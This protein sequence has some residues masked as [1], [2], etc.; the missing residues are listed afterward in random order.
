MALT[1]ETCQHVADWSLKQRHPGIPDVRAIVDYD[2][3]EGDP[4][5][6]QDRRE[7]RFHPA[8]FLALRQWADR[9]ARAWPP[10]GRA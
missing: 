5:L 1:D 6:D 8:D 9:Q 7:A 4:L 2:Q 10:L 3:P